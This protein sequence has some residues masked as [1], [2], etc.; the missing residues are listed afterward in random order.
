MAN[1]NAQARVRKVRPRLRA[2]VPSR[3]YT[4]K[5][6]TLAVSHGWENGYWPLAHAS[7][8]ALASSTVSTTWGAIRA[9]RVASKGELRSMSTPRTAKP[10]MLRIALAT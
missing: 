2:M 1:A 7:R 6:T 8:N 3:T 9:N 5:A 4:A 10:L